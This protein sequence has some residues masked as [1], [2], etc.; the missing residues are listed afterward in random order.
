MSVGSVVLFVLLLFNFS[1]IDALAE[2]NAT[3]IAYDEKLSVGLRNKSIS[4]TTPS[5]AKRSTHPTNL[6]FGVPTDMAMASF[7]NLSVRQTTG[8]VNGQIIRIMI[9]KIKNL[10]AAGT[11]LT[12]SGSSC[13]ALL[14]GTGI[15]GLIGISRKP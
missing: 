11:A 15:I 5:S 14:F 12:S 13:T 4:V 8:T 3:E 6:F 10:S 7:D 1:P 9:E 2:T